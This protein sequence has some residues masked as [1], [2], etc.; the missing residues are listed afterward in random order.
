VA[1]TLQASGGA[2]VPRERSHWF[3][4]EAAGEKGTGTE[5]LVFVRYDV[6]LEAMKSLLERYSSTTT[7]Q[8]TSVMTAFPAMAWQHA[9][10]T[11]GVLLTKVARP[12]NSAGIAPQSVVMAAGE[13]RIADAT[14]FARRIEEWRQGTGALQLMVKPPGD[15]PA[16]LIELKRR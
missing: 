4:V 16:S 9:E 5:F 11:G 13:Q 6:S 10:F 7:V 2:A 12:F 14:S 1:L 3:W 8:G 15:A